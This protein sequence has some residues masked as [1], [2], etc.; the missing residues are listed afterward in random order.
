MKCTHTDIILS[1]TV[2][3]RGL[4]TLRHSLAWRGRGLLLTQGALGGPQ[5]AVATGS[6]FGGRFGASLWVLA[7]FH[8]SHSFHIATTAH[9]STRDLSPFGF[10][11]TQGCPVPHRDLVY[12]TN[13]RPWEPCN[14]ILV[15]LLEMCQPSCMI[16]A[17]NTFVK[18]K[19]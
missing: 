18:I 9:P 14:T 7:V 1:M 19:I 15:V 5:V 11:T 13:M 3:N 2:K 4:F 10:P 17:K 12:K 16:W 8:V 6:R